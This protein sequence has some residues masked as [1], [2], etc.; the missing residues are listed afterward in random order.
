[1][2]PWAHLLWMVLQTPPITDIPAVQVN[3][4]PPLDGVPPPSGSA[5]LK[6]DSHEKPIWKPSTDSSKTGTQCRYEDISIYKTGSQGRAN[7]R[8]TVSLHAQLLSACCHRCWHAQVDKTASPWRWS[9]VFSFTCMQV[10]LVHHDERQQGHP[11]R[12]L[13]AWWGGGSWEREGS[14][15]EAVKSKGV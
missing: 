13:T 7:L 4:S 1:M 5:S 12:R 10:T 3:K 2:A 9:V 8:A 6:C 11:G 15:E 14:V